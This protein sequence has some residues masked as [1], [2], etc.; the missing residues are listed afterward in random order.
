MP[1]PTKS[2]WL[3]AACKLRDLSNLIEQA[4]IE[5]DLRHL[6]TPDEIERAWAV[7]SDLN[8]LAELQLDRLTPRGG[9]PVVTHRSVF[10]IQVCVPR[11]W[12]DHRVIHFA[13]VQ[14]APGTWRS[15]QIR[16]TGDAALAGD[17]E[18]VPCDKREGYVHIML[19]A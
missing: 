6:T 9:E 5:Y 15:W 3:D 14:Y 7:M 2:E 17:P 10:D 18:R 13:N 8:E 16:R 12:E 11:D 1:E 19:D 4:L